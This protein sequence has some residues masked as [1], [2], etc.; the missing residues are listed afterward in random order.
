VSAAPTPEV[1]VV[2]ESYNLAEGTGIDRFRQSLGSAVRMVAEHG[3]AELLVTDAE[4]DPALAE[5]LE[6]D[7]PDA[8]RVDARGLGYDE[9]KFKAA[10]EASGD[11]VLYLDGDCLPEPG[12]LEAH[13]DAFHAGHDATSGFTRYDGGWR[14]AIE[15]VLDFGFMLPVAD[16]PVGCYGSNNAGFRRGTMLETRHPAGPMRC[17]CY[18]HAQEL[19]KRGTPVRLVPGARVRHARVDFLAERYR[20]GFD[21]VAACWVDP[22]LREAS[23]LRLGPAAAPLFYA[24]AV[25]LDWRRLRAGRRDLGLARWQAALSAPLFPPL[26]L[27][28]LAGIVRAL[29]PGGR[30]SG[31]GLKAAA[32]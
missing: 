5:L 27:V 17:R 13:L 4:G 29:A 19:L 32:G 28:D 12:W 14:G 30:T 2:V 6:R 26:R 24:E 20:R 11:V 3:S 18:A 8:R 25:A 1:T 31:V 22:S 23:W 21:L 7:A 9:A 10:T 16:R 15:T